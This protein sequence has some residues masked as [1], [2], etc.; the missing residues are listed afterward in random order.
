MQFPNL[1]NSQL[2]KISLCVGT[3]SMSMRFNEPT[4]Y[5]NII[6]CFSSRQNGRRFEQLNIHIQ[7]RSNTR[8]VW[9]LWTR[10]LYLTLTETRTNYINR[11]NVHLMGA[12]RNLWNK[13]CRMK[14][15]FAILAITIN[16]VYS[17][18]KCRKNISWCLADAWLFNTCE[19]F[20]CY[21]TLRVKLV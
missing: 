19:F 4:G 13:M 3:R 21:A 6:L 1:T 20:L 18:G 14:C 8:S 7:F 11:S 15:L 9:S 10:A 12:I 5:Y 17:W 2:D 16:L